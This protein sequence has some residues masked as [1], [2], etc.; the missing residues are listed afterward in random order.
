MAR[1]ADGNQ[2][3]INGSKKITSL[4]APPGNP[5]RHCGNFKATKR[6]SG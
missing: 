3:K 4:L 1:P 5:Q 2:V 6:F